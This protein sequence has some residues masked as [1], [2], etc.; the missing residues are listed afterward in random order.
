MK[1]TA[2]EGIVLEFIKRRNDTGTQTMHIAKGLSMSKCSAAT[3]MTQMERKGLIFR[4]KGEKIRG[5]GKPLFVVFSTAEAA[6]E[7]ENHGSFAGLTLPGEV[8]ETSGLDDIQVGTWGIRE[9]V[10]F[11]IKAAF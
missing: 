11:G 7:W 4:A 5:K 2:K 9:G 8:K 1:I 10:K 6:S 3:C